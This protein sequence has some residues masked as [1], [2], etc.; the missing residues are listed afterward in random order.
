MFIL[1]FSCRLETTVPDGLIQ[2]EQMV[3][4]LIDIH[5]LESKINDI[6]VP[7]DS[8][9][10]LYNTLELDVFTKHGVTK[11]LYDSSYKFYVMN[12]SLLDDVYATVVDS[13]NFMEK[14]SNLPRLFDPSGKSNPPVQ[15]SA[16][17]PDKGVDTGD[18]LL[19]TDTTRVRPQIKR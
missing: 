12:V 16:S 6:K 10:L 8:S 4:L 19:R 2:K 13:L 14:S 18:G 1:L 11:E 9:R 7:Y 15:T 17:S 5:I 3:S